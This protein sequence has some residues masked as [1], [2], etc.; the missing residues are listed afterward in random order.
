MILHLYPPLGLRGHV[1]IELLKI[2]DT[3]H[4]LELLELTEIPFFLSRYV[5]D[6]CKAVETLPKLR[7][8]ILSRGSN[9]NMPENFHQCIQKYGK[10]I[11]SLL[12]VN[13]LEQE[14]HPTGKPEFHHASYTEAAK[15]DQVLLE[16]PNVMGLS[17]NWKYVQKFSTKW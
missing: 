8:L 17:I 5:P 1:P 3:K 16:K 6:L 10:S 14:K 15:V 12:G 2:A 9:H 4:N 11:S 13:L 7:I